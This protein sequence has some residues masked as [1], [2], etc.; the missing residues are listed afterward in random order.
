MAFSILLLV[1]IVK[2]IMYICSVKA[3]ESSKRGPPMKI[4]DA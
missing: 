3:M 2:F 4:R 1:N